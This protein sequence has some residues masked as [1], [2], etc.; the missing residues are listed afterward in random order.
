MS[1]TSSNATVMEVGVAEKVKGSAPFVN[2]VQRIIMISNGTD[3]PAGT[4]SFVN[5]RNTTS[6]LAFDIDE[7]DLALALEQLPSVR[8]SINVSSSG[9]GGFSSWMVTFTSPGPQSMLASP[10]EGTGDGNDPSTDCLLENASLQIQRVVRGGLPAS[11]TFRLRLVP[12]G[13]SSTGSTTVVDTST[14]TAPLPLDAT[15]AEVQ[16]A[17]AGLGGGREAIVTVARNARAEYGLEWGLAL[18]DGGASSVELTDVLIDAPG[19][20]CADGVTGPATAETPCEFPFAVG[21]D[22]SDVHFTCAGAKGSNR[23]WCSTTSAFNESHDWGGCVRCAKSAL[24]GSPTMHV[25]SLRHMFRL[26]GRASEVSQ[27][28]SETVY[29]PREFWNAWLGGHDEVSAYWYDDDIS[30]GTERL[31]GARARSFSQVFVAPTNDPPVVTVGG[32]TRVAYEGQELLLEDADVLDPDL[33]DR[34]QIPIRVE[35]EAKL[36]TLA[37]KDPSGLNFMSGTPEPHSSQLLMVKG[38]LT[39]VRNALQQVYYRPLPVS[40]AGTLAP[41]VGTT[42]EVQ[43]VELTAPVVPMVQSITTSTLKGYIEGNFTLSLNC[44]AFFEEVDTIFASDVDFL[45]ETVVDSFTSVVQSSPLLAD[46][47]AT[48]QQSMETELRRLLTS[49]VGLAWDRANNLGKLSNTTFSGNSSLTG[50]FTEDMV[51]YRGATAIV[52][53]GEPN[54]QGGFTWAATLIDVP[55]S[56]PAFG[57]GLN[58]L[59]GAGEGLD[60]SPYVFDDD[61]SLLGTPSISIDVMQKASSLSGPNGTFSLGVTPGGEMTDPLPTSASGEYVATALT[62]LVGVGAVQVSTGPVMTSTSA[63][64][65]LGQYWEITFLQSGSP[66]QAGDL[67][68]LEA[69]AVEVDIEGATLHVSEVVKGRSLGDSVTIVVNDLGNVGE[70]GALEASAAWNITIIPKHVAP[71]LHQ[72]DDGKYIPGDLLRTVEGTVLPLPLVLASHVSPFEAAGDDASKILQYLVRLTCSRGAVKPASSAVG[73]GLAVTL[74]STTVTLLNGKLSDINRALANLRYYAPRRYRGVD[75]V[76]VAARVAG[77]GVGGGWGTTKMYVFVDGSNDAPELSAP[78]L[79]RAKAAVP[80]VV[81]GISVS[82]DDTMGIITVTV[83]AARGVVSF[84]VPHRLGLFEGSEEVSDECT[85]CVQELQ[86]TDKY[87]ECCALTVLLL[88]L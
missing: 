30:G 88:D 60:G 84:P 18:H 76:E 72:L 20:W 59:T 51:S 47:P 54:L 78:R 33:A 85:K 17:V 1:A 58:N 87:S 42:L 86:L 62:S 55:Q 29:H 57:V 82:D 27:A 22:G 81:G 15:A 35:L 12:T 66:V 38:S 74:S 9:S 36:G 73:Q 64:A 48:G 41:S 2:E 5:G 46:A 56:F 69:T 10:C 39:A 40:A 6:P 19:P 79:L 14:T 77:A 8:S 24:V 23:G 4:F 45:N 83:D 67:P 31:S 65:V 21:E 37:L 34:T 3:L 50:N 68:L 13:G 52:S 16:A 26:K 71:I 11:G 25:A 7:S 61:S 80:T 32:E 63:T 28:L 75:D 43:R 70:G 44:S 49:C 53:R